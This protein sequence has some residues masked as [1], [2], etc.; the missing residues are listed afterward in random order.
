MN[1]NLSPV[2]SGRRMRGARC[3]PGYLPLRRQLQPTALPR[4][5]A[6]WRPRMSAALPAV[7]DQPGGP[8]R[9]KDGRRHG[10]GKA[11]GRGQAR[12]RP[13]FRPRSRP[14][15]RPA[16]RLRPARRR[17]PRSPSTSPRSLPASPATRRKRRRSRPTRS[18]HAGL[19]PASTVRCARKDGC[20]VVARHDNTAS[21]PALPRLRSQALVLLPQGFAALDMRRVDGNARHRADLDALRLVEMAHAFG[22]FARVD[23]IDLG[24]Q[25]DGLVRALGLAHIAVDAL[26]GNHQC[27]AEVLHE[28]PSLTLLALSAAS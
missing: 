10:K 16:S 12:L 8:A 5:D 26:V 14:P 25:V 22:A 2:S 1:K 28:G 18:C 4:R 19:D 27:H 15:R 11:E 23:L 24:P 17:S 9:C 7:A 13:I 21:R 20:R 6:W 3:C